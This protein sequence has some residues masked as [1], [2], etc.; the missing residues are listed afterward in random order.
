MRWVTAGF[1]DVTKQR[2][3]EGRLLR[4]SDSTAVVVNEALVKRDFP[5]ED[6]IGKRFYATDTTFGTIV[7]VVSDIKN[8][9]PIEPAHPEFYL[10]ALD[11]SVFNLMIRVK[12][13]DPRLATGTV[14][15]AIRSVD[16]R[17]AVTSV[18]PMRDVIADSVRAQRFFLVA[19]V[20]FAGIAVVLAIAGL[21][22]V[23]SYAVA[24]RTRELGIRTAL[25]ST[26]LRT[27]G[28]VAN[29]G[30]RLIAIGIACGLT[31]SAFVMRVLQASLYGLSPLDIPTW[32]LATTV[33][34]VMGL[35]ATLVPS[36]RAASVDPTTAMRS[37]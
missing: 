5:G 12:S 19:I 9:G 20:L 32:L 16:P 27:V 15:A 10:P 8:A 18:M 30:L 25:G 28:L 3:L 7:G 23:L 1:F 35:L 29:G 22:G 21:H 37:E 6:P 2:L 11:A 17:A 4:P 34:A 31:G 26:P 33:L 14:A 24:Q 13:G 36:L